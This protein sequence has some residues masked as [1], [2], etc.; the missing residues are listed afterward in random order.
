MG[1]SQRFFFLTLNQFFF[2]M[3]QVVL[4]SGV[5]PGSDHGAAVTKDRPS[6]RGLT[7]DFSVSCTA[8]ATLPDETLKSP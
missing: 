2:T 3:H 1:G 6:V 8:C 4:L 5:A 7:L